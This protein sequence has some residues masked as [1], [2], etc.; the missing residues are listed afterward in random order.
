MALYLKQWLKFLLRGKKTKISNQNH[1]GV[2]ALSRFSEEI[3][4]V[5]GMITEE[6]GELLFTLSSCQSIK[7]DIV[8]VGSWQGRST[9]YLAKS[10][11]I[12]GNGVV[13]AIDHFEGNPGKE[14]LY[15]LDKKTPQELKERFL[16]N[17]SRFKLGNSVR[18]IDKPSVEAARILHER[19]VQIRFLF[20]DGCH[21]Y[22]AVESDFLSFYDLVVSGG[23]LAFDDYSNN[24]PGVMRFVEEL[25]GQEYFSSCYTHQHLFIGKKK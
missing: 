14:K 22:E 3:K 6:R 17:I 20:I 24:F 18:L 10:V 16:L 12:T 21:T 2:F 13:Y 7:G 25:S 4:G 5:P 9:L 15:G 23:T 8:E 11:S 1:K 19:G